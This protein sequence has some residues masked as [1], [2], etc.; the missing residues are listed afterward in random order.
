MDPNPNPNPDPNPIS[1]ARFL[2]DTF[3]ELDISPYLKPHLFGSLASRVPNQLNSDRDYPG[4]NYMRPV[5]LT[6]IASSEPLGLSQPLARLIRVRVR[7][8]VRPR[9]RLIASCDCRRALSGRP[10]LA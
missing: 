10:S 5:T 9:A 2:E 4:I 7:V 8:R 6:L 1:N 3:L